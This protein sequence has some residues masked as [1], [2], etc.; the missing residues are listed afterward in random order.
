LPASASAYAILACRTAVEASSAFGLFF[1]GGGELSLTRHG[2]HGAMH[3]I[4]F[5][6]GLATGAMT[7]AAA[8]A[9]AE[10]YAETGAQ[11]FADAHAWEDVCTTVEILDVEV[12]E[13]CAFADALASSGATATAQANGFA[14]GGALAT[15][16]SAGQVLSQTIV[17]GANIEEFYSAFASQAGSFSM[18]EAS[19]FAESWADAYAAAFANAYAEACNSVD[20]FDDAFEEA[21]SDSAAEAE[22][23]AGA[24]AAAFA[25]AQASAFAGV[26]VE[27]YLPAYYKNENGIYDTIDFGPNAEVYA[28]AVMQ[29]N[30]E[31]PEDPDANN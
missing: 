14:S 17:Y 18:T 19:A 11:V 26:T 22:A 15:S 6:G 5:G 28:E 1:E 3:H 2:N 30:C 4:E 20:V 12:L 8:S 27:A 25:E 21:C 16:G 7:L 13:F 23:Y 10:V 24:Y 29:L 9:E 31:V